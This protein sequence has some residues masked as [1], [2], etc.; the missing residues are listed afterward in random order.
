ME[1]QPV[2]MITTIINILMFA[3]IIYGIYSLVSKSN[4]SR[5]KLEQQNT[6]ILEKL[7]TILEKLDK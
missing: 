4:N 7:N 1:F 5:K 2:T 3:L 6:A